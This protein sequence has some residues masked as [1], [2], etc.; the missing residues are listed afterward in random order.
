MREN[1]I[2]VLLLPTFSLLLSVSQTITLHKHS[3]RTKTSPTPA[4]L[5]YVH[6][7]KKL[8]NFHFSPLHSSEL[9]K[10]EFRKIHDMKRAILSI[11]LISCDRLMMISSHSLAK[12]EITA[13][14]LSMKINDFASV[15]WRGQLQNFVKKYFSILVFC[16]SFV[17]SSGI[18]QQLLLSGGQ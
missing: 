14:I 17:E 6:S 1:I 16:C 8:F 12:V 13:R 15:C 9:E 7:K 11:S 4:S 18:R 10:V 3:Q 5:S 2:I